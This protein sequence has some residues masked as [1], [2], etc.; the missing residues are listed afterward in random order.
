MDRAAR[1][2]FQ[3]DRILLRRAGHLDSVERGVSGLMQRRVAPSGVQPPREGELMQVSERRLVGWFL[4]A[5]VVMLL[6]NVYT[7]YLR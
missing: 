7:A 5:A 2:F 1:D 4:T 6:W 3:Q